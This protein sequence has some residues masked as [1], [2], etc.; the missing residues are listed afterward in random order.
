MTLQ[1]RSYTAGNFEL[2]IDGH[3]ST[4]YLKSVDGGHVRASVV[5]EPIG[6]ENV[7]IK[8]TSTVDIHHR[9]LTPRGLRKICHPGDLP[10]HDRRFFAPRAGPARDVGDGQRPT[11]SPRAVSPPSRGY[12]AYPNR[13][14]YAG[15]P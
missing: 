14:G 3:E 8:H 7:R 5:D 1:K 10:A 15:A 4:A 2:R 11:D 6:P 13:T 9:T 12:F